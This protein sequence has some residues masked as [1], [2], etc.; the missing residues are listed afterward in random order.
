MHCL[1]KVSSAWARSSTRIT[2]WSAIVHRLRGR[3][4]RRCTGS[5]LVVKI[6]AHGVGDMADAEHANRALVGL[7]EGV[8]DEQV[9]ALL[10]GPHVEDR[11]A[12]HGHRRRLDAT[13]HVAWRRVAVGVDALENLADDV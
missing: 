2:V 10:L 3:L 11:A 13:E 7:S 12:A 6:L 8:G 4:S 1:R 5:L 9:V